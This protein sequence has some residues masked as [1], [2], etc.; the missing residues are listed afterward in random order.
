MTE[1]DH[2]TNFLGDFILKLQIMNMITALMNI[3]LALFM[4]YIGYKQQNDLVILFEHPW[5]LILFHIVFYHFKK[6]N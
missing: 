5:L 6:N 2:F 3:L 4:E 1:V